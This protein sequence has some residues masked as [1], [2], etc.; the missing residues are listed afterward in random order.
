M[1]ETLLVEIAA[2]IETRSHVF[3]ISYDG[4]TEEE[5][6]TVILYYIVNSYKRVGPLLW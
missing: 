2:Q 6:E 1:N 4:H 5:L 3:F